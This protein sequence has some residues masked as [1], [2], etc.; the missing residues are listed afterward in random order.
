MNLRHVLTHHCVLY[1][2]VTW[3]ENKRRWLES[4][5]GARMDHQLAILKE[6]KHKTRR[7]GILKSLACTTE[8]E[9]FWMSYPLDKAVLSDNHLK[10]NLLHFRIQSTYLWPPKNKPKPPYWKWLI[11]MMVLW[12]ISTKHT[13]MKCWQLFFFKHFFTDC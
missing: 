4:S 6:N 3:R 13:S 2:K 7:K 1:V 10:S 11:E 9:P 12:L 8:R 5:L